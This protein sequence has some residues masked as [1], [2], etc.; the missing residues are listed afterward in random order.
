[1]SGGQRQR[2]SVARALDGDPLLRVL[3]EP[4][5]NLDSQG[6]EALKNTLYALKAQGCTVILIAHRINVL[7]HVDKVLVLRD[8]VVHK[9][10]PRDEVVGP[11]PAQPKPQIAART[12]PAPIA[13]RATS[14]EEHTSD[15]KSL[16]RISYA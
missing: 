11:V 2:P 4:N 10:A 13:S 14:S 5:A 7:Q 16:M 8:G 12:D 9:F 15:L 6:E 1:M 3:D